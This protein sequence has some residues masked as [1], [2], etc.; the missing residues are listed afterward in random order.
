MCKKLSGWLKCS[1]NHKIGTSNDGSSPCIITAF[2][3]WPSTKENKSVSIKD[4]N[5]IKFGL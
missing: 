4:V 5:D 1:D 2:L 3:N